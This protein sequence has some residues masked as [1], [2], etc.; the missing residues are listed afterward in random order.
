[1]PSNALLG[2]TLIITGSAVVRTV[3]QLI[4]QHHGKV[5]NYPLIE[6]VE[7][8]SKEDKFYLQELQAYHWLIFTSQNAVK[9]F[10]DKCI[11]HEQTIPATMK[12]AAVGEKTAALLKG[13]GYKIHFMPTVYSADVFVKEFSMMPGERALFIRGSKAKKTIH[14]GTGADEWTVYETRPCSKYFVQLTQCLLT[15]KQPIVIFASPSAVD[16]YAEHIEPHVA[17]QNVK[18]ASIGHVTTAALEKH[19]VQPMVQPKI[20]TMQ[21]VIEQLILEEQTK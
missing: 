14:E 5:Y 2:K 20:Y 8:I 11:R 12:I 21:A 7:K 18:F 16:I 6:T 17:W 9:S 15:E 13:H 4:E 10:V 1:M 3:E 19:G